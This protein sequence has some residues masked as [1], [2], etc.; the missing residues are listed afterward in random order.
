MTNHNLFQEIEEDLQRQRIEALWKRY[1]NIILG[2]VLFIVLLTAAISGWRT[3][4]VRTEQ[5]ATAGI[6]ELLGKTATDKGAGVAALEEFAR[7]H[8]GEA[9]G[10]LARLN[11]ANLALQEGDADRAVA[12]YDELARDANVERSFRQLADLLAVQIRMDEGDPAALQSRLEP[13]LKDSAWRF[14]AREFSAHLALKA[15]DREKAKKLFEELSLDKEA[16]SSIAQR[17]GD[18]LRWLN[19]GI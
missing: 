4:R 18:M 1:G 17:S 14:T 7:A 11:A 6:V 12:I 10:F 8:G 16:P 5:A 19:E 2:V 13:L 3:Y 15:D 9:H